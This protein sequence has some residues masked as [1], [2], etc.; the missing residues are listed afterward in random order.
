MC[1]NWKVRWIGH[2]Y[3]YIRVFFLLIIFFGCLF[4]FGCAIQISIHVCSLLQW[5]CICFCSLFAHSFYYCSFSLVD[6]F[7]VRVAVIVS[8]VVVSVIV[9]LFGSFL[10]CNHLHR[11]KKF[12]VLHIFWYTTIFPPIKWMLF[13]F[14]V[15]VCVCDPPIAKANAIEPHWTWNHQIWL[16]QIMW[17]AP[18]LFHSSVCVCVCV[19]ASEVQK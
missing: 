14:D 8:F 13:G 16:W 11:F 3:A 5:V 2:F 6:F 9:V 12:I 7:C 15:C 18:L 19:D 17:T 10:L 4:L 1:G